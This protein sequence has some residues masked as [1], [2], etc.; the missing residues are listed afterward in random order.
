MAAGLE[1]QGR[2]E[3]ESA[4]RLYGLAAATHAVGRLT[5]APE[6]RSYALVFRKGAVVHASSSDP[7][8]DLG[9]FLVRKGVLTP[10]RLVQAEGARAAAG[11]EL[12]G[13]LVAAGLVAP[14]EVAALL[15][16]HGAALVGRALAAE[17][18]AFRWE[19]GVAAPPS[20]F[21][22][23]PPFAALC[24]AVRA[25]DPAAVMRRLGDRGARAI[26]RVAGR[27]RVED[28]RLTAQEARAAA[29]LDGGHSPAELAGG[30]PAEATTI[31]RVALLL[32]ELDLVAFGA[33][34]GGA[35]ASS[36]VAPPAATPPAPVAKPAPTPVP[37]GA[38]TAAPRAAA[39][40]VSPAAAPAPRPAA[41]PVPPPGAP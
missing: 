21:P 31:L 22:L 17:A 19:P 29:L 40:H 39:A 4:L 24:A 36:P 23:G 32:A 15:Q 11:G 18:G 13:A 10:E 38:G 27:I 2:L 25:L 1:L 12:A 5:V 28:L 35:P 3:E 20:G 9:R 7:A 16:E 33:V 30:H 14:G 37:P 8:D 26:S 34:R 6:G 41:T